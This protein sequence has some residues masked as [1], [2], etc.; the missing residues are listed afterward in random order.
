[1][2][3]TLT[4]SLSSLMSDSSTSLTTLSCCSSAT[5][6]VLT[7]MVSTVLITPVSLLAVYT[8]RLS[9]INTSYDEIKNIYFHWLNCC[10]RRTLSTCGRCLQSNEKEL[11]LLVNNFKFF[12]DKPRLFHDFYSRN[13]SFKSIVLYAARQLIYFC[14]VN[15]N[16]CHQ[17]KM[18]LQWTIVLNH[19]KTLQTPAAETRV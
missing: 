11:G 7:P 3:P 19:R 17:V 16:D 13:G 1:M 2:I 4:T 9:P 8:V 18:V 15:A 12:V 10:E 5:L 14:Q 6:L